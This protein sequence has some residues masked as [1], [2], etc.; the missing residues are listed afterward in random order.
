MAADR[1]L[2][3]SEPDPDGA[4]KG[5]SPQIDLAGFSG[6]LAQLLALARAHE[7]D[8]R[9]IS[10]AALPEQLATVPTAAGR[11]TPLA[12][13]GD[14]LVMAAWLVWLRS[15]LLLPAGSPEQHAA[16]VEA[17]RLRTRLGALRDAQALA[18]WLERRPQLGQEVFAWGQPELLGTAFDTA[19][20][21][22]VIEFLWASVALFD[23]DPAPDMASVYRPLSTKLF[24]GASA[25]ERILRL[26][27][28][29]PNGAP[30]DRLLPEPPDTAETEARCALRQRSAWASTLAAGLELAKQG[31]VVMQ[32]EE[33]FQ[34][35][36]LSASGGQAL[37]DAA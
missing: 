17:D 10:L 5:D 12:H 14:W 35:I 3:D 23:D 18:G 29:A 7:I 15:K 9:E 24:D 13:R 26:L 2:P 30:L 21:V 34:T 27:A 37:S 28:A 8:L 11:A 6:P 22:D 20:Q 32:Q 33:D 31:E 36:Q 1:I 4:G 19:H 25:R 16:S